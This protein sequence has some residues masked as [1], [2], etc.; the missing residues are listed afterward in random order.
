MSH[1]I[2]PRLNS[3]YQIVH[4]QNYFVSYHKI[5]KSNLSDVTQRK[6]P[7]W[8]STMKKVRSKLLQ[9]PTSKQNW[10]QIWDPQT[11]RILMRKII[12][13]ITYSHKYQQEEIL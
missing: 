9:I 4:G 5:Y 13:I 8:S 1:R 10:L 11:K 12:F 2:Y 7:T 6:Y 3:S